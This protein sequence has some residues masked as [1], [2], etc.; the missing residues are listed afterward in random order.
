[1]ARRGGALPFG[2]VPLSSCLSSAASPSAQRPGRLSPSPVFP[3]EEWAQCHSAGPYLGR[4]PTLLAFFAK[5]PIGFATGSDGFW[6][7]LRGH[8]ARSKLNPTMEAAQVTERNG[9]VD[10]SPEADNLFIYCSFFLLLFW[11]QILAVDFSI[12]IYSSLLVL[13]LRVPALQRSPPGNDPASHDCTVKKGSSTK[14]FQASQ[15]QTEEL[16]SSTAQC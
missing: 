9:I 16:P 10:Q 12:P 15:A 6:G 4:R 8:L 14:R 1:M 3:P 7:T 11:V 5:Q 13:L 2:P